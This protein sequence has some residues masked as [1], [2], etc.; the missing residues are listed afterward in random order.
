MSRAQKILKSTLHQAALDGAAAG[1][2]IF[3]CRVGRKEPACPHGHEDATRDPAV[4]DAW[5]TENPF[6]IGCA[7]DASGN[8]VL[9]ADPPLGLETLETLGSSFGELPKTPTFWITRG[10]LP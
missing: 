1:F 10:G 3:P 8:S 4:I 5:W 7:P 2:F 9:D 6:N